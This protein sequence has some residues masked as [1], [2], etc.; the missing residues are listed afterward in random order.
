[1]EWIKNNTFKV[2]IIIE[3]I[4]LAG[5]LLFFY[6]KI[7]KKINNDIS[8]INNINTN[9]SEVLLKCSS[10]INEIHSDINN[11]KKTINN[12]YNNIPIQENNLQKPYISTI[13][14]IH[15]SSKYKKP[16]PISK[17]VPVPKHVE[18]IDDN[19]EDLLDDELQEEL[20]DLKSN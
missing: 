1:M 5:L 3:I 7:Y 10:D 2:H 4:V 14:I 11:L 6:F 20:L 15:V 9:T 18:I 16:V 12:S 8:D 17:P 19:D 13:P